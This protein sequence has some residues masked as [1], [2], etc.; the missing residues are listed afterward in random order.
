MWSSF[1][2]LLSRVTANVHTGHTAESDHGASTGS[3][4]ISSLSRVTA[5]VR[6]GHTAQADLDATKSI[7]LSRYWKTRTLIPERCVNEHQLRLQQGVAL[8]AVHFQESLQMYALVT[9]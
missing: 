1:G 6:T 2:S 7:D 5:N 3:S 8:V 9:Q 4:S